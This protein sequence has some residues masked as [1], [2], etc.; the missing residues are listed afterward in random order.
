MGIFKDGL[1]LLEASSKKTVLILY[2]ELRSEPWMGACNLRKAWNAM[3]AA[4]A[5]PAHP[6]ASAVLA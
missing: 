4:H 6:Q 2:R 3:I 1:A 5:P